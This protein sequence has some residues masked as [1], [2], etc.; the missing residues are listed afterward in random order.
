VKYPDLPLDTLAGW[1]WC[2]RLEKVV[3]WQRSQRFTRCCLNG[4]GAHPEPWLREKK[5]SVRRDA[6][7]RLTPGRALAPTTFWLQLMLG[8]RLM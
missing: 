4:I 1:T 5:E 7:S 2:Q 3:N 6:F 8:A